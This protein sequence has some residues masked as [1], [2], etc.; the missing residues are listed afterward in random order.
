MRARL[1]VVVWFVSVLC[2]IRTWGGDGLCSTVAP[3]PQDKSARVATSEYIPIVYPP[4]YDKV[5]VRFGNRNEDGWPA[6]RVWR[7]PFDPILCARPSWLQLSAEFSSVTTPV[8]YPDNLSRCFAVIINIDPERSRIVLSI[9]SLSFTSA[10]NIGALNSLGCFCGPLRSVSAYL[11]GFGYITHSGS[12]AGGFSNGI[13]HVTFLSIR[14]VSREVNRFAQGCGLNAKYYGLH[15][16]RGELQYA[17][18]SQSAREPNQPPIGRRFIASVMLLLSAFFCCLL[19]GK[20][21][22]N[23]GMILAAT[24]FGTSGLL[25]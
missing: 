14:N 18:E 4:I 2:V 6:S 13:P 16:Q 5:T 7:Y 25:G 8:S 17:N 20:Y 23:N 9:S 22:Y 3:N 21:L 11:G 1:S 10:R 12:C 15:Y 19:G 24:L